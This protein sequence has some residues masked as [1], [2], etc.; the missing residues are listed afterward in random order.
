MYFKIVETKLFFLFTFINE[1]ILKSNFIMKKFEGEL[2]TYW[3][4]GFLLSCLF[5]IDVIIKTYNL[6]EVSDRGIDIGDLI[7]PI[8]QPSLV[9]FIVIIIVFK[10][11]KDLDGKDVANKT[12]NANDSVSNVAKELKDARTVNPGF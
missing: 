3:G 7:Y 4:L 10:I 2:R 11:S 8:Y 1:L 6:I 12:S 5:L 9:L